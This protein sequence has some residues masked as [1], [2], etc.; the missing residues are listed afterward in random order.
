MAVTA[1]YAG[2]FF[3]MCIGI[4]LSF[5]TKVVVADIDPHL[6]V[7]AFESGQI[8]TTLFLASVWLIGVCVVTM[9][10]AAA[11]GLHLPPGFGWLGIGMYGVF[12]VVAVRPPPT[13]DSAPTELVGPETRGGKAEDAGFPFHRC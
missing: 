7:P 12:C 11:N 9:I 1:A 6:G 5:L 2:P 8:P 4:G 10:Y 13:V 3:N